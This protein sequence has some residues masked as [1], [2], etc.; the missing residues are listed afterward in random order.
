MCFQQPTKTTSVGIDTEACCCLSQQAYNMRWNP[1]H[2]E[3][4]TWQQAA[5]HVIPA[6]IASSATTQASMWQMRGKM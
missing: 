5:L 3:A 1:T 6:M 4:V 2:D